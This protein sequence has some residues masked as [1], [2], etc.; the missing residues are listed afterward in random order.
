M[1]KNPCLRIHLRIHRCPFRRLRTAVSKNITVHVFLYLFTHFGSHFQ[2]FWTLLLNPQ[3]SRGDCTPLSR[4]H[5]TKTLTPRARACSSAPRQSCRERTAAHTTVTSRPSAPPV[6]FSKTRDVRQPLSPPP[7]SSRRCRQPSPQTVIRRP[8]TSTPPPPPVINAS[9]GAR[10]TTSRRS[11]TSLLLTR[12]ARHYALRRT[13]SSAQQTPGPLHSPAGPHRPRPRRTR[14]PLAGFPPCPLHTHNHLASSGRFRRRTTRHAAPDSPAL[15]PSYVVRPLQLRRLSSTP[16]TEPATPL[17]GVH[18]PLYYYRAVPTTTSS[19]ALILR[20]SR[21]LGLCIHRPGLTGPGRGGHG[22]HWLAS[23]PVRYILTTIWRPS[24][25]FAAARPVSPPS[26][27]HHQPLAPFARLYRRASHGY[28][29]R[30]EHGALRTVHAFAYVITTISQRPPYRP[31]YCSFFSP[32]RARAS[33]TAGRRH[34]TR[35]PSRLASCL[36]A[37]YSRPPDALRPLSPPYGP[38]QPLYAHHAQPAPIRATVFWLSPTTIP[39]LRD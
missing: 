9:H 24:A 27:A 20:P 2:S 14:L 5:S 18:V 22:C 37:A 6:R 4:P 11:S 26:R 29:Q 10:H 35:G 8:S 39:V 31:P 17:L 30:L 1:P 21:R 16:R 23:R 33:L 7:D 38:T 28:P 13:H 25:A 15:R 19:V 12:R 3:F 32:P 36:S 34:N